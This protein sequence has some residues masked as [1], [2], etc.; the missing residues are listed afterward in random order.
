MYNNVGKTI[1]VLGKILGVIGLLAVIVGL[2]W[3]LTV[4]KSPWYIGIP[5]IVLGGGITLLLSSFVFYGFGQ[6]IDDVHNIRNKNE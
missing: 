4:L 6:L 5:L 3:T 1:C 2:I